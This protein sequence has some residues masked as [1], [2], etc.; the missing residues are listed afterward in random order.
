MRSTVPVIYG[1]ACGAGSVAV[2]GEVEVAEVCAG[3]GKGDVF[4]V[5]VRAVRAFEGGNKGAAC[6]GGDWNWLVVVLEDD[7]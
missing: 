2:L 3:G 5:G 1:R 6:C 4:E 7:V